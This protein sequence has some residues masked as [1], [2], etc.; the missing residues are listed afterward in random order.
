MTSWLDDQTRQ[1]LALEYPHIVAAWD[2]RGND[3]A[4]FLLYRVD[5]ALEEQARR[6]G[7]LWVAVGCAF[8]GGL[9]LGAVV[10]A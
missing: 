8:V 6:R 5:K 1:R 7:I 4:W 2:S 3:T 10:Y 9:L